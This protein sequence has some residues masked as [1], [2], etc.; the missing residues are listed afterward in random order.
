MGLSYNED[1]F[2]SHSPISFVM[3]DESPALVKDYDLTLTTR[4]E[5]SSCKI[6]M[7]LDHIDSKVFTDTKNKD[8]HVGIV[9]YSGYL[10]DT[11]DREKQISEF[12]QLLNSGK[13]QNQN[14]FVKRFEGFIAQPEW[15]FGMER[16][17]NVVC[18][19]WGQTLK[20]Y[21][22]DSNMKDGDCEVKTIIAKVQSKLTGIKIVADSYPGSLKLGEK[23]ETSKKFS[24][25]SSGKT[26]YEILEEC[27]KRMGKN[28]I[29][30]GKEIFITGYKGQPVSWT[31]YYGS[32]DSPVYK[33]LSS[34]IPFETLTL[35]YGE[36]G[37]TQKSGT[38]VDLTSRTTSKKGKASLTKVRYPENSS[39]TSLTNHI[40]RIIKNNL[41]DSELKVLAENIYKK[42]S[43]KMMTGNCDMS[44]ANPFMDLMDIVTFVADETNP[45]LAYMNGVNF[46]INSITETYSVEGYKQKID[47]D[48]TDEVRGTTQDRKAPG[49]VK[50]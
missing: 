26:Y 50:K 10:I 7:L 49:P 48:S 2:R 30:K 5:S 40:V 25:G 12:M 44:F 9:I 22:W 34:A 16:L 3:M 32:K 14:R 24:Y 31:M 21:K 38:V 36:V 47:F 46:S 43:K 17:L 15:T 11:E 39:V 20:E 1:Q 6:T 41:S 23:D 18:F 19:D 13:A 37:E 35:R 33:S 42:E 28:V 8:A 45:D 4:G 29:V 27:A